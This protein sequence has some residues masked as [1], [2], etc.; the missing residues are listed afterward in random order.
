M[1]GKPIISRAVLRRIVLWMM[2]IWFVFASQLVGHF[3]PVFPLPKTIAMS[4]SA[5]LIFILLGMTSRSPGGIVGA[6]AFFLFTL[7]LLFL[8]WSR[9]FGY[10]P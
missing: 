5:L 3:E 7:P 9:L 6:G 1:D 10:G 2:V 8:M 4:V